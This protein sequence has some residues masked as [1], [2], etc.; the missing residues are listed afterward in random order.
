MEWAEETCLIAFLMRSFMILYAEESVFSLK[1]VY[2]LC[3]K[4]EVI[5]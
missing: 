2:N 5:L 1:V 4:M 3:R